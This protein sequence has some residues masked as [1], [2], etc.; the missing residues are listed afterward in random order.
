L[1][2]LES[3]PLCKTKDTINRTKRQSSEWKN[4]FAILISNRGLISK[5]YK[6]L[7]K[8]ETSKPDNPIKV[9]YRSEQRTLDVRISNG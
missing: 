9:G 2:L 4:S 6:Q 8:L 7:K 5:I 3:E 1:D